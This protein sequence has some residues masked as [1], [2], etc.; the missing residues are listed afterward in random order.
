MLF[1][2]N[3]QKGRG[4]SPYTVIMLKPVAGTARIHEGRLR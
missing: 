3:P 1:V 4:S 2:F